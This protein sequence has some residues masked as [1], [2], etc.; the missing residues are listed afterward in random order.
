MVPWWTFQGWFLLLRLTF[1][2]PTVFLTLV[3]TYLC[4]SYG[5]LFCKLSKASPGWGHHHAGDQQGVM[6]HAVTP[7]RAGQLRLDFK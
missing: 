4:G 6:G 7:P 2:R 5:N 1:P 3:V